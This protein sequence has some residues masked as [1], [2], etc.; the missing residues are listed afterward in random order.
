MRF[1]PRIAPLLLFVGPS[2]DYF[3]VSGASLRSGASWGSPAAAEDTEEA[4]DDDVNFQE[5]DW[6]DEDVDELAEQSARLAQLAA[7]STA[8][9]RPAAQRLTVERTRPARK[10]ARHGQSAHRESSLQTS[11]LRQQ[12]GAASASQGSMPAQRGRRHRHAALQQPLPVQ[13]AAAPHVNAVSFSSPE[14]GEETEEGSSEEGD[15]AAGEDGDAAHGNSSAVPGMIPGTTASDTCLPPCIE[16]RGICNDRLC[17]CKSPFDGVRCEKERTI[18]PS[19]VTPGIAGLIVFL[20]FIAGLLAV[21]GLQK[22]VA[23]LTSVASAATGVNKP[24]HA[25]KRVKETWRPKG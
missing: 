8:A 11:Q 19:R 17:F 13:A 22:L 16:G 24:V 15:E 18:G 6:Q 1:L 14:E 4:S 2:I 9:P 23:Q 10:Q 21:L 5:Q 25:N 20:G 12:L 7:V 3:F